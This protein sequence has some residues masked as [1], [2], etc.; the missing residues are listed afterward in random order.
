MAEKLKMPNPEVK[1]TLIE[2]PSITEEDIRKLHLAYQQGLS[3][4]QIEDDESRDTYNEDTPLCLSNSGSHLAAPSGLGGRIS[5]LHSLHVP[6][7]HMPRRRHSWI[8]G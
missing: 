6:T 4:K 2:S 7:R 8:C 1:V 5:G 3:Q